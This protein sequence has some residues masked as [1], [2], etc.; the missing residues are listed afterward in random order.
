MMSPT[1]EQA[2]RYR[3]SF[4]RMVD[5]VGVMHRAGVPL[6]AGTDNWA[7]FALPRELELYVKAGI[8]PAEVLRIAT[9]NGARFTQTLAE[10]GSIEAGKRADLLLVDGDPSVDIG[11]VRRAALVMKG[12]VAYLPAEL[13]ASLGVRP[14]T[15]AAAIASRAAAATR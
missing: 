7:G 12:G 13:L 10:A 4:A 11:A 5:F 3:A 8:P 15:P 1:A 9:W 14:F 6:V 2:V